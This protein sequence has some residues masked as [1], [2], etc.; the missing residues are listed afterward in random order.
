MT[1]NEALVR[2][3]W[4]GVSGRKYLWGEGEIVYFISLGSSEHYTPCF[5]TE[6][7]AWQ[8]AAE[9]TLQRKEEIRC[10]L[11]DVRLL[12]QCIFSN[13]EMLRRLTD[14]DP[15]FAIVI[16]EDL[17]RVA[18]ILAREQAHLVS[19]RRGWRYKEIE[20]EGGQQQ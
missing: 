5:A 20:R 1:D 14:V 9:F 17:M 10:A 2:E 13:V 3:C 18:R 8:A 4:E 19:L 15:Q 7:A 11:I 16:G 6:D 12:E